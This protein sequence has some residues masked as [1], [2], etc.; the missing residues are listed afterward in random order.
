[1]AKSDDILN[2]MKAICDYV[3]RSEPTVLK[4]HRELGMPIRKLPTEGRKGPWQGSKRAI[5]KWNQEFVA[6]KSFTHIVG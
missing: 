3:G 5:D 1:M 6:G 4:Y 2:G